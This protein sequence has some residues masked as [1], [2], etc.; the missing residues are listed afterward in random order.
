[1]VGFG[2]LGKRV[3]GSSK[4]PFNKSHALRIVIVEISTSE[5][6]GMVI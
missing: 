3:V 1:V 5:V 2:N 4:K 6:L